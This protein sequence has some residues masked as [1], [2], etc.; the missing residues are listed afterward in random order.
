VALGRAIVRQPAALLL[1]EP[2]SSLDGP[3]RR[4]LRRELKAVQRRLGVPMIYV[5]HD[6]AEALAMGDRIAVLRDGRIEQ[7]GTP[8]DVYERPRSRFVGEFFGPQGMNVIEGE[9]R[10]E[11][12]RT[13]FA[14]DGLTIDLP[15]CPTATSNRKVICGF[16]PEEVETDSGGELRGEIE[17]TEAVGDARYATVRTKNNLSPITVR[18]PTSQLKTETECSLRLKRDRLHWFDPVTGQRL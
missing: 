3:T 1:D 5:T 6:Q 17:S 12:G 10:A 2:L 13:T 7:V 15:S 8:E 4:S 9:L 18:L 14:V 11:G 16:R